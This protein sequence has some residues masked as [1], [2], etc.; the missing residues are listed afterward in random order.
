MSVLLEAK[1]LRK[2]FG[3]VKAVQ[4]ISLAIPERSIYAVIGPNGAGKSTMMNLLSGTYQPD[5]GE[6]LFEGREMAGLPAHRRVRMGL[7][8]TFQKIRLFKQLSLLDNVLAGFHIHHEVPAWQYLVPGAAFW[9]DWK[10]CREEGMALLDFVGLADLA[11]QRAG[12]LAYGQQ[13]MLEIARAMATRPRLFMLDEPAA[14]LNA[15]EVAFLLQRLKDMRERGITVVVVEHNMDL[16]MNVADHVF[17]MDHGEY[18]F[19]GAPREVQNNPK[20]IDAYLGGEFTGG[21][22]S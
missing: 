3:G 19:D 6:L 2:S 7:A 9:R 4:G 5:S 15:A 20:V 18:L 21:L 11:M 16:V 22:D 10:R 17:V 12:S 14:G 8:R 13:R 1:A